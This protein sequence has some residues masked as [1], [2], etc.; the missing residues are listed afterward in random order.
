MTHSLIFVLIVMRTKTYKIHRYTIY[1][2]FETLNSDV[3]HVHS[4]P[5]F[6]SPMKKSDVVHLHWRNSKSSES[7]IQ[8]LHKA[9]H[10]V[11]GLSYTHIYDTLQYF[12]IHSIGD[13][14]IQ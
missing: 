8:D 3:V 4:D 13:K 1:L 14:N 9:Q 2:D 12:C 5:E 10:S 11:R 7:E 6:R